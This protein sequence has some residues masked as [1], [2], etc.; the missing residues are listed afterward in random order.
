MGPSPVPGNQ[1]DPDDMFTDPG[2]G[3]PGGLPDEHGLP[4]DDA[5]KLGDFA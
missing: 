3:G 2:V 4:E 1:P 5:E